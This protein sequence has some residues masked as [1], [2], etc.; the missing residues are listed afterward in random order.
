V[1]HRRNLRI[2]DPDKIEQI[3]F[4]DV[5]LLSESRTGEYSDRYEYE[6]QTRFQFPLGSDSIGG[7]LM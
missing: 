2:G 4:S 3:L 1:I 5:S 6:Q 7:I